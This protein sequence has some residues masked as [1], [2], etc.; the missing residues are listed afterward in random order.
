[1]VEINT[2][3]KRG[4][5]QGNHAVN[6]Q[7]KWEDYKFGRF[8]VVLTFWFIYFPKNPNHLEVDKV[9]LEWKFN[10]SVAYI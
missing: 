6:F 8:R 1:M 10:L 7:G 5:G 2:R 9:K 3:Q 4:L